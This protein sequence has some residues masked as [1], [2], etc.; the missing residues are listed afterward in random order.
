MN[1]EQL[2][3]VSNNVKGLQGG[4]KRIK[5]FEYLKS[6]IHSNGIAFI[7]ETHSCQADE[8]RWSDDFQGHLFFSH[9][10]T[11]SCGVAIGYYGT[12][13]FTLLKQITDENGRILVLEVN[14]ND[15]VYVLANLY[16][17]YLNQNN[18]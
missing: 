10:K 8:K 1:S 4:E 18:L 16:N 17:P 15:E 9:G 12:K 6:H 2:N 7:Q 3:F 13:S 14:I 11:N 5:M